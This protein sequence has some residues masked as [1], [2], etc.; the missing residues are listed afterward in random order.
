M[1]RF[2][3]ILNQWSE[4]KVD[5]IYD[6]GIITYRSGNA[7]LTHIMRK[8]QRETGIRVRKVRN[9]AKA[10][11]IVNYERGSINDWYGYYGQKDGK[12]YITINSNLRRRQYRG[13]EQS[14][15]VHEVGHALGL[16]HPPAH[17]KNWRDTIMSYSAP[18]E[19]PWFSPLDMQAIDHLYG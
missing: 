11:I 2:H 8:L 12:T 15:M 13:L 3:K 10:D 1:A 14:V 6:D 7:R 9:D 19:Q 17:N 18:S 16:S 5:D 4:Q